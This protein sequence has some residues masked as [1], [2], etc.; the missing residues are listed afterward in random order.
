MSSHLEVYDVIFAF[1]LRQSLGSGL[2]GKCY[3][4]PQT[5]QQEPHLLSSWILERGKEGGGEGG[6][7]G[8]GRGRERGKGRGRGR[9]RGGGRGE[10]ERERERESE[11]ER[12]EKI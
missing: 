11:R 3:I 6:G 2:T 4:H 10:R 8:E 12:W 9:G 1:F 5:A 7:E